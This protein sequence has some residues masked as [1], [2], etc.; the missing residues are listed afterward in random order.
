MLLN[1]TVAFE[2]PKVLHGFAENIPLLF[3]FEV[4]KF[5]ET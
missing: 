2:K 3:D 4:N 1:G 5:G